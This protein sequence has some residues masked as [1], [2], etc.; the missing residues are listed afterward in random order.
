MSTFQFIFS[1]W[2]TASTAANIGAAIYFF[3]Y[4]PYASFVDKFDR[5]SYIAKLLFCLPLNTGVSQGISEILR[6]ELSG[7]GIQF[8]NIFKRLPDTNFSF[9]EVILVMIFAIIIKLL[10]TIYIDQVFPGD[11]GIPQKWYFPIQPC[12]RFLKRKRNLTEVSSINSETMNSENVNLL[13]DD[14]EEEPKDL[15][16]GIKICNL[17]KQF[18]TKFA[19]KKLSMNMYENQIT[20]LLGHNGAGKTTT[21]QMLTGF[22]PPTRGTAYIDGNDVRYNMKEARRSIGLCPQHNVLFDELSVEE[23]FEFFCRLKGV[24]DDLETKK[25]TN[26]YIGML[27]LEEKRKAL[28]KTLSGGMKRKLS[29]GI[30]LCGNSKIVICDEPTSGLDSAARRGLWN[31][32]IQEKK[33]RTILLTTHFLDEADV[34]GDRIAIMCDGA[35]KTVGSSFFLKKRFGTGYKLTCEKDSD[36]DSFALMD[37]LKNFIPD[38][39][40]ESDSPTEATFIISERYLPGFREVFKAL[41]DDSVKLN[42]HSFGCSLTT[43]EDVFLKIGTDGLKTNS[44]KNGLDSAGDESFDHDTFLEFDHFSSSAK[45]LGTALWMSQCEAIILKKFFYLR[46]NYFAVIWYGFLSVWLIYIVLAESMFG[47]SDPE[48]LNITIDSYKETNILVEIQ[49]KDLA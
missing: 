13:A 43:L 34:L 20:V 28:S 17:T 49:E 30:A 32:L 9:G 21:M 37:L 42:L 14:F 33:N 47:F 31:L 45:L 8:S 12:I 4:F 39:K 3:T 26:K 24:I 35:L 44:Y 7:D 5:L 15:K 40:M 36:C 11:Y 6:L 48:Y 16:V 29:I 22:I 19:V 46:R 41:E 27:D 2:L 38:V 25:E 18:G 23:H 1:S 10:L